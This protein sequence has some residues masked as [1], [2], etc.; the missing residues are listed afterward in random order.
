MID[1]KKLQV[2]FKKFNMYI[3]RASVNG[4]KILST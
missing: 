2:Q 1:N 4:G 3:E